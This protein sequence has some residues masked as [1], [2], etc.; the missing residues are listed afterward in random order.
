MTLFTF[1]LLLSPGKWVFKCLRREHKGGC[2][3]SIRDDEYSAVSHANKRTE[4]MNV[5]GLLGRE[6][7]DDAFITP[8]K[9]LTIHFCDI[10]YTCDFPV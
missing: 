6:L 9:Q 2:V 7:E 4:N 10:V 5:E 8:E 1:L 3:S